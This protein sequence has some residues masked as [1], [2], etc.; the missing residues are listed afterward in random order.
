MSN[1]FRYPYVKYKNFILNNGVGVDN[2][3][4][5]G[6]CNLYQVLFTIELDARTPP[7]PPFPDTHRH[8][9]SAQKIF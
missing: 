3:D 6:D 2:E 5:G 4:D 8:T 1:C 7:P 9:Y